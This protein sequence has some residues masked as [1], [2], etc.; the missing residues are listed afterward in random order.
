MISYRIFWDTLNDRGIS[1]Y[2]L[3]TDHNISRSLLDKLRKDKNIEVFTLGKLCSILNC[4]IE[5]I[6]EYI[7]D[8]K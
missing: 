5:D 8:D 4:R 7:P 6:V 1:Q 2:A 3:Y